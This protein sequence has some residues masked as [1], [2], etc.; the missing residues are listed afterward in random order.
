MDLRGCDPR[1]TSFR[2][3]RLEASFFSRWGGGMFSGGCKA[4]T[5]LT[6]SP[7]LSAFT[8]KK[9]CVSSEGLTPRDV[10]WVCDSPSSQKPF[11]GRRPFFGRLSSG[12]QLGW[13][14]G[15]RDG[16][17]MSETRWRVSKALWEPVTSLER[18]AA[19]ACV[20][21]CPEVSSA[22]S[23]G[24]YFQVNAGRVGLQAKPCGLSLP[25]FPGALHLSCCGASFVGGLKP[26]NLFSAPEVSSGTD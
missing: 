25:L 6:L 15:V 10:L 3:R 20:F 9:G 19:Q 26:R 17:A 7:I 8:P 16:W 11:Q 22:D 24:A 13:C 12:T 2:R 23:N 18:G 4:T 1:M 5:S 21:L 14:P